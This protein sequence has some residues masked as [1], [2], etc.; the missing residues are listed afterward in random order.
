MTVKSRLTEVCVH[1]PC[2]TRRRETHTS[3]TTPTFHGVFPLNS[4]PL[5]CQPNL[6]AC[7]ANTE[8]ALRLPYLCPQGREV[9]PPSHGQSQ[10]VSCLGYPEALSLSL[11]PKGKIFIRRRQSLRQ[12]YCRRPFSRPTSASLSTSTAALRRRP[13]KKRT[14]SF[15]VET[16]NSGSGRTY[17]GWVSYLPVDEISFSG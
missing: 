15:Q 2:P 11:A 17:P 5:P 10:E 1:H 6:V 7:P 16:G 4:L 13:L 3:G 8:L 9:P 14:N 12:S